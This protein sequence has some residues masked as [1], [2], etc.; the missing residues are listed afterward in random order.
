MMYDGYIKGLTVQLRSIKESDAEV[1]FKMRSD[2][3]K[4]KYVHR[5]TGTVEDQRNY[6]INQMTLSGDYLFFV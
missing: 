6:I 5:A 4:T 1:T 3:E 2:P